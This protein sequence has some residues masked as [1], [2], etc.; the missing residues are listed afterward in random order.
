LAEGLDAAARGLPTTGS[1]RDGTGVEARAA[2]SGELGHPGIPAADRDRRLD[3]RAEQHDDV[4]DKRGCR[5]MH[6]VPPI[7]NGLKTR[8]ALLLEA[9]CRR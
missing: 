7:R 2:K 8:I 5:S 4:I 9:S 6:N 1:V 3:G